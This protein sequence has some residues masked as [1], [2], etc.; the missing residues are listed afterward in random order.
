LIYFYGNPEH[1]EVAM[2]KRYRVMLSRAE[3]A[4]LEALAKKDQTGAKRF[5]HA[6]ILLLCDAGVA[7]PGWPSER[8]AEALG[9]TA[10]TIE[11]TKRRL[12]EGGM[13][14]AL[15]RKKRET[16]PRESI[17]DGEKEARLIALA[18]S[19]APNGRKRWTVRLLAERLVALDVFDHISK[20]SV[21][22]ALKKTNLSLT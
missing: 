13:D 18:C 14:A 19:Q 12:L 6:R 15:D 2:A 17:F 3:R 21:Q 1:S 10:R 20:S 8:I 11:H 16:P 4:E 9:V 7:G 5:V 22:N